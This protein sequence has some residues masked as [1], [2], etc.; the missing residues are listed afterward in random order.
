VDEYHFWMFPVVAG[1]GQRLLDG[2]D[3]THLSLVRS[4]PFAS[5]IVV[6]VYEPKR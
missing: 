4:R 5:G 1:G 6:L 3:T 2:L